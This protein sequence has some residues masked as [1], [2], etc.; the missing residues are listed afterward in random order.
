P[1][2]KGSINVINDKG[3]TK[4]F[5]IP[6]VSQIVDANLFPTLTVF[7]NFSII[8]N[9]KSNPF[10]KYKSKAIYEY[11]F[12]LLKKAD[13]E[14]ENK[15]DEQIRFLSGGQKQAI[16]IL[17]SLEHD[18]PILLMDEPTASLDPFVSKKVID[19]AIKEIIERNGILILVSHN[20]QDILKYSTSIFVLK[21]GKLTKIDKEKYNN[22]ADLMKLM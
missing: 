15:I 9:K 7:E 10:N 12:N 18:L 19:L 13:M 17:F 3:V 14:L 21:K 20:L 2:Q 22:E 11:C 5:S 8:K 6:L 1:I 16:S 4:S